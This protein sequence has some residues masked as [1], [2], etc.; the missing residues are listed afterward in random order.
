[1]RNTTTIFALLIL[2]AGV[3]LGEA[4][5]GPLPSDQEATWVHAPFDIGECGLCHER[6]DPD[7]PGSITEPVTELC[8]GCHEE[9]REMLSTLE[10]AHSPARDDCTACH[11]PHNSMLPSLLVQQPLELC[12]SCHEDVRT[13]IDEASTRHDAVTEDAGC[14]ACHNPHASRVE[15]L[16]IDL[17]YDLCVRCHSRDEMHDDQGQPLTNFERLLSENPVHHGP[18]ASKDCS[19]CHQPHGGTNFRMLVLDYPAKF[20]SPYTPD[21]YALCFTCHDVE[22]VS[23]PLTR[24]HTNFRDGDRNLHHL[25]VNRPTR[26][27][28]CRACHE[29]H[30]AEQAHIIRDGVPYGTR[31]W[32]LPINFEKTSDGGTCAKTCHTERSYD[33][34]RE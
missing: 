12:L 22:M 6:D 8:F 28:T 23:E 5:Q 19:A 11:N 25:H 4:G 32:I 30:A 7:S 29:V 14:M 33:R 16:L 27:R 21:N 9:V 31:G 15:K 20:Y 1:M 26:G 17:P 34:S 10:V 3:S 13:T 24:L 18:V 2:A